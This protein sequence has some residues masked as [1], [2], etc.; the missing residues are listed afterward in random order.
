MS[1]LCCSR[2]A[3]WSSTWSSESL[4][5]AAGISPR[6]SATHGADFRQG[7]A[8]LLALEDDGK[9]GAIAG[10]ID[11]SR[12]LA[13]RRKE[14]AILI[15]AQRPQGNPELAREVANRKGLCAVPPR[16]LRRKAP[17]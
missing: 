5:L 1:P 12:A 8:E 16:G 10:V 4:R 2:W 6:S 11:A 3:I 14:T 15:E 17:R 7:E 13:T 9:S